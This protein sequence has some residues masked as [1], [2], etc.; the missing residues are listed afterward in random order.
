MKRN[1]LLPLCMGALFACAPA[2]PQEKTQTTLEDLGRTSL[3][4]NREVL[5]LR[6]RVAQWRGLALASRS[7]PST[8]HRS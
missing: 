2:Q 4:K 3:D 8:E 7:A 5:A 6:Q 1:R